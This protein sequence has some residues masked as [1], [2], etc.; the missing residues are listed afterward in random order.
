MKC[1][2]ALIAVISVALASGATAAALSPQAPAQL[3]SA[4]TVVRLDGEL[5]T[6][7]GAARTGT[8][9]M[10]ASLYAD[11]QDSTPLWVE[12]QL[13]TLDGAGRY[14]IF[15][16]ATL[17]DGVPKEFFLS[18]SSGS[19]HWL[20]IAVQ[21]EAEQ[22]RVMLVS[23]PYA[24]KAREA[25]TLAG[26]TA[27]DF[28]LTE[29]L[30]DT[31]KSALKATSAASATSSVLPTMNTLAKFTDSSGTVGS[32]A[33]MED[34]NGNVGI[35]TT[36]PR[37]SLD[38]YNGDIYS[39]KTGV[40][41]GHLRSDDTMYI[42]IDNNNDN[43]DRLFGILKGTATE[44]FR[45]QENGNVGIAT[46][47][48]RALL[49]VYNGDIYFGRTSVSDGHLRSDDSVYI[50]IDNKNN[51]T[52]RLFGILK[53]TTT[54]LFRV[55]ENGNVGIGTSS[56]AAKLDVVG[57]AHVSGNVTI[58][59]NIAAKYQDVA[60]WVETPSPLEPGTIVIVDPLKPNRVLP[61]PRAYD[62]RVAGA[63]SRQPGLVLGERSDTKAMVAQSGR[64][65][66]K[67]DAK[68]GAIKIGDLLVTS[69]TPG[70]AMRS[71]PM[72][73]GGQ[74]LHRPGTL[75]GKALEPLPEGTGDILVLLT[76]Q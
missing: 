47:G 32:S 48:P 75:L 33:V 55:Q 14:T 23:V 43:S 4:P 74:M 42:N 29:H 16:G 15:V 3:A 70:Y 52:D 41:D 51:N 20:G 18:S 64:V 27:A 59:G 72:R 1:F 25:D 44:L 34:P 10:V 69:P 24:L 73:I 7:T 22:P 76:L 28:V 9:L 2:R 37:A 26:K 39:G 21:G 62:T 67:A 46:T 65:R 17:D 53:G 13:V 66:V 57:N 19:G 11:K 6:P 58:D 36:G 35:G 60:E 31:V 45:V 63:V 40:S 8:V 54:E 71:R 68:Y 38:V 56:P 5:K 12:Q 49:D 50:N 30:N 61:A